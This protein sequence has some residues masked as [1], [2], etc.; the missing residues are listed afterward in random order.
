MALA[1]ID[2]SAVAGSAAKG[3]GTLLLQGNEMAMPPCIRIAFW[4]YECSLRQIIFFRGL[5]KA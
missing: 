4:S 5:V 1:K 2:R 3:I